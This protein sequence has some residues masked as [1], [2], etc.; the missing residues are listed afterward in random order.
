MADDVSGDSE[1]CFGRGFDSRRLHIHTSFTINST[2]GVCLRL[3]VVVTGVTLTCEGCGSS[4]TKPKKEWNRQIRLNPSAKFF[5][6]SKCYGEKSVALTPN[7]NPKG[8]AHSA[9]RRVGD[10]LTPFRIFVRQSRG[11]GSDVLVTPEYLKGLWERQHGRCHLSNI[12]MRLPISV[13]EWEGGGWDYRKP[14]LDRVDC[15][16]GYVPGNV[17]FVTVMANYCRNRF[18]DKDLIGF[19]REVAKHHS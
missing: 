11:R 17:R 2:E 9:F 4:F 19:C 3:E 10:E 7:R 13:A 6:G 18:E 5:C 14:S 8:H 12:Q 16:K 15:T 1:R